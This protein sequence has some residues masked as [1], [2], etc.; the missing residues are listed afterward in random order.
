MNELCALYCLWLIETC[1]CCSRIHHHKMVYG[2]NFT[3]SM[4]NLMLIRSPC[5]NEWLEMFVNQYVNICNRNNVFHLNAMGIWFFCNDPSTN[6]LI[7]HLFFFLTVVI[8]WDFI[9]NYWKPNIVPHRI[10]RVYTVQYRTAKIHNRIPVHYLWMHSF[11][12]FIA[13]KFFRL[14][15]KI[16]RLSIHPILLLLLVRIVHIARNYSLLLKLLLS[17]SC[18]YCALTKMNG[19]LF[20]SLCQRGRNS[21]VTLQCD[22][23]NKLQKQTELC[24][25]HWKW[26]ECG[27]FICGM[28]QDEFY[29]R[30]AEVVMGNNFSLSEIRIENGNY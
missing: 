28:V 11:A 21:I 5:E 7:F 6:W 19:K 30:L 1:F 24:Q 22:K 10:A 15:R 2:W 25:L 23:L 16:I 13:T 3:I 14:H 12:S 17:S 29:C 18:H 8:F 9:D 27:C 20:E 26:K 4:I